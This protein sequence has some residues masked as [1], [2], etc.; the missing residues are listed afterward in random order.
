MF[1]GKGKLYILF[2][3]EI[4]LGYYQV[5]IAM[6]ISSS[7]KYL[8]LDWVNTSV[9]IK[10]MTILGRIGGNVRNVVGIR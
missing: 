10:V 9:S 3:F 2:I 6:T 7:W 4:S 8:N 5:I 1:G